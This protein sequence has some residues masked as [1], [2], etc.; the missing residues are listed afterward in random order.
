M[1]EDSGEVPRLG[2]LLRW[3]VES[4]AS[5][6]HLSHNTPPVFRRHGTLAPAPGLPAMTSQDLWAALE[7]MTN[8][9]D[10]E[11]FEQERELDKALEL[12]GV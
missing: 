12:A 5:D 7:M 10:R 4:D 6:L 11:R 9:V 1:S 3:M 8:E 2:G